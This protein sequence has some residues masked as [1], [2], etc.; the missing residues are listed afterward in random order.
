MVETIEAVGEQELSREAIIR[1]LITI[2]N[3][4][5]KTVRGKNQL[6]WWMS[7]ENVFETFQIAINRFGQRDGHFGNLE[8]GDDTDEG[9][10]FK[11]RLIDPSA[12]PEKFAVHIYARDGG[13]PT[14]G[15]M[16][17]FTSRGLLDVSRAISGFNFAS[18]GLMTFKSEVEPADEEQAAHII[19]YTT[20]M[21]AA[22]LAFHLEKVEPQLPEE[23]PAEQNGYKP[24]NKA[25]LF[26]LDK[27]QNAAAWQIRFALLTDSPGVSRML[28]SSDN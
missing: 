10:S 25:E 12:F 11:A 26:K 17:P 6:K 14:Y 8:M 9:H 1:Q 19:S 20:R 5:T 24:I 27:I 16:L 13:L 21:A 28:D 7:Q 3:S 23:V 22:Q 2:A 15:V 18:D 4:D